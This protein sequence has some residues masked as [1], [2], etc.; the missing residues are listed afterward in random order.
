MAQPKNA[1][2]KTVEMRRCRH[3]KKDPALNIFH[4]RDGTRQ[5]FIEFPVNVLER[6]QK[7]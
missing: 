3:D 4:V 1:A 2:T 6:G 5:L 7:S